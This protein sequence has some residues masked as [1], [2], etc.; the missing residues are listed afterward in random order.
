[1]PATKD[2][3]CWACVQR[4]RWYTEPVE[5]LDEG[6][7]RH[8]ALNSIPLCRLPRKERSESPEMR[9]IYRERYRQK[10]MAEDKEGWLAKQRAMARRRDRRKRYGLSEEGY[11]ALLEAQGGVCAICGGGPR[12]RRPD[13]FYVDH[14]HVSGVVRGLLCS[15]CNLMIGQASEDPSVLRSGADYLERFVR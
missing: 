1:M 9:R 4:R 8:Q 6:G 3:R 10:A 2:G 12:G 7:L 15:P 13:T 5:P 14:D 11:E